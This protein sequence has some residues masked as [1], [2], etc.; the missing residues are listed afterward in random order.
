MCNKI[1]L[2][3]QASPDTAADVL[4]HMTANYPAFDRVTKSRTSQTL[5]EGY[6]PRTHTPNPQPSNPTP[7]TA[8]PRAAP[9]RPSRKVS[10]RTLV[11]SVHKMVLRPLWVC[12]G[13]SRDRCVLAGWTRRARSGRWLRP[14]RLSRLPRRSPRKV[15]S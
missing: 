2:G 3:R 9:P 4:S 10:P 12:T 11:M 15:S 13:H 14:S 7:R 6:H 5:T 1:M 8:F